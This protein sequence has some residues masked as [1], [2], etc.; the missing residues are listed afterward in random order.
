MTTTK[1]SSLEGLTGLAHQ[2]GF[3]ARPTLLRVLTDL[4]LQ[5]PVHTAEEEQQFTELALRLLDEVDLASRLDTARRLAGYTAVPAAVLSRLAADVPDIAAVIAPQR[6]GLPSS[7]TPA[8]RDSQG[9]SVSPR[10]GID[11][12]FFAATAAERAAILNEL[13]AGTSGSD[14]AAAPQSAAAAVA[15]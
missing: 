1:F 10:V 11:E 3:D 8:Q 9:S 14:A 6:S 7:V 15:R 5:Q 13:S 4:Y 2:E 12:L